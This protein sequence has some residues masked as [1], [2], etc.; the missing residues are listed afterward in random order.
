M[1]GAHG[2]LEIDVSGSISRQ[3][4]GGL[5]FTQLDSSGKTNEIRHDQINKFTENK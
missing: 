5:Y 3:L 2:L 1:F 4:K